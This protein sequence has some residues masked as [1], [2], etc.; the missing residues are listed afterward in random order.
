MWRGTSPAG[1]SPFDSLIS[2]HPERS[3]GPAFAFA[4]TGTGP[5]GAPCLRVRNDLC[6]AVPCPR[7][8]SFDSLISCHQFLVIL[9][10]AKDLLS[11]FATTGTGRRLP[12]FARS[13]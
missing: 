1:A 8:L 11:L 2:C 7:C 13:E 9:S 3:E 10:E 12:M 6:G 5:E 4:P